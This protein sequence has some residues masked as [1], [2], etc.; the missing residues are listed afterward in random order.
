MDVEFQKPDIKQAVKI[1]HGSSKK[2]SNPMKPQNQGLSRVERR[3]QETRKHRNQTNLTKQINQNKSTKPTVTAW[4]ATSS[5][6]G[7]SY[8]A[9]RD[10]EKDQG[11]PIGFQR[12]MF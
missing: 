7:F 12:P 2:A 4:G 10:G 8:A 6:E 9:T 5:L 11:F 3:N 1:C